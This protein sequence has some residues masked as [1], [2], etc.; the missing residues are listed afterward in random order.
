[1]NS[2]SKRPLLIGLLGVGLI[3]SGCGKGDA[4]KEAAQAGSQAAVVNVLTAKGQEIST[5]ENLPGRLESVREAVIVP[6]VSGIVEARNF[7][8]GGIVQKGQLLYQLDDGTY[9]ANL[10]S[11]EATLQQAI[12]NRDLDQSNVNRYAK[13]VKNNAVSRLTYDQA[14]ADLKVQQANIAAA[15][16][17]IESAKINLGYTRIT[18]PITG[19]I[20]YSKVTEGAYVSASTTEMATIQQMDPMYVDVTQSADAFLNLKRAMQDG[21]I[22][23][24]TGIEIYLSDGEKYSEEGKFLFVNQVVAE[25]TGE[26]M[27]RV[28][29]PN[30]KGELL[31]GMY[32]RV[33][34]PQATF[35]N[36]YLI[37]QQ[38]VTRGQE[39]TLLIAND[40]GSYRSQKVTIAGQ[41][42]NNW[43]VTGGLK[44]GDKVIVQGST[45]LFM[46]A[47]KVQTKPWN[48]DGE[49]STDSS[50]DATTTSS[51]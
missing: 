17:S 51:K 21:A 25:D 5:N 20:G 26:V 1:M 34:I 30:P 18:A 49:S 40:D 48:P 35:Q 41:T 38:A 50:Q 9:K 15:K 46:G 3:L 2:L 12:A 22:Q 31:P 27:V 10:M 39:D 23:K 29:V 8:E 14:V 47:Q 16:A 24:N 45:A 11:A 32:V 37:P 36:A 33:V 19:R 4:A 42:G 6:R 43:I 13:L 7:A 44:D 28:Q